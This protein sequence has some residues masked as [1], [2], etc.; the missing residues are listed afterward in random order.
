VSDE[1]LAPQT[2]SQLADHL[3]AIGIRPDTYH[4]YGAHLNDA[5]V[6]DNR[7][8][9]WVVFYSERGG[10]FSVR[11]HRDEADACADLLVRVTADEHVFF[12][13][14]AGP[15]PLDEADKAFEK[16][17]SRQGVTRGDLSATDWKYEDV[18]SVEGPYWRRYFV[19]ITAVRPER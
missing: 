9:G 2:R 5:F 8:E 17:L 18:P 6:M 10:E 1:L 14:V 19:R 13:L 7:P 3:D 15:A 11:V 4:L 12:E 16:W